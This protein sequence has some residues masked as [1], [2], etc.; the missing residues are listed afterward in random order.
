MKEQ[1]NLSF[2]ISLYKNGLGGL[3]SD[4]VA[5]TLEHQQAPEEERIVPYTLSFGA[6]G[7][8]VGFKP[9]WK[10]VRDFEENQGLYSMR[11][12]AI[13]GEK[14]MV[15]ISPASQ[16]Y[17]LPQSRIIVGVVK[18][19][20]EKGVNIECRALSLEEGLPF[21]IKVAAGLG[22]GVKSES[23]LRSEAIAFDVE[24]DDWM[25]FLEGI[26]DKPKIWE[27]IRTGSDVKSKIDRDNQMEVV[28]REFES[29]IKQAKTGYEFI[30]VGARIEQRVMGLGIPL[31]TVGDCGV[32][33]SMILARGELVP[34]GVFDYVFK[35]SSE[36]FF[37][38]P[39]PKC[40]GKIPSGKGVEV[41]PHCGAKKSDYGSKC[42]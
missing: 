7:E 42:D 16:K 21:C 39:N 18:G 17:R 12:L 30:R 40:R 13:K 27:K 8:P 25:G 4:L 29:E 37:L 31:S 23:G 5:L 2:D 10:T 33:N 41:C 36:N 35:R 38:C 26:I 34:V 32:L 3:R 28:V 22:S 6:D 15:W 19:I 24:S 1:E 14:Y 20:D 9:R 11:D